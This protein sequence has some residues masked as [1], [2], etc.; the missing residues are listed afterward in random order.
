MSDMPFGE[1]QLSTRETA[2]AVSAAVSAGKLR[3]IG[4]TL[5]STNMTDP[6]EV[7]IR[8]NMWQ[9]VALYCPGAIITDRTGI[10]ARPAA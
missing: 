10:E 8:R 9:I 4:P 5:Y 3:K 6:V 2:K 7:V 1:V